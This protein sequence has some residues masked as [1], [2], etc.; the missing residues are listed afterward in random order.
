MS[1]IDDMIREMCPDEVNWLPLER[2]ASN[3]RGASFQK[4]HLSSEGCPCIHY[5]EIYTRYGLHASTTVSFVPPDMVNDQSKACPGSVILSLTSE[6]LLD[7]C[8]PVVW[9]GATEIA[10]SA[11]AA[12]VE[13]DPT[14]MDPVFLAH[15]FASERFQDEKPKIAQGTKIYHTSI[16]R[17]QRTLVPVPP[18]PIQK[19]IVRILDTFTQL[20]AELEAELEARKKQYE[21]YLEECFTFDTS[22]PTKEVRQL[23][24]F[25]NGLNKGKDFFGKGSPIINFTD[26]FRNRFLT[27]DMIRGCVDV[28]PEE[29]Q[30]FSARAGDLF[31]TRTSETQEE[32]G[33]S[34]ALVDDVPDCVFSGFV[35]RARPTTS[36][37]LPKYAAYFFSTHQAR[38]EIVRTSTFTTRALTSGPKLGHIRVPLP[39]LEQQERVVHDLDC[40]NALCND[41]TNGIPA[42]IEARRKQYEYYRDKLL[43]FPRKEA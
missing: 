25:K 22:T 26:V 8:T 28:T 24:E 14:Q 19:E 16:V 30:R 33:M 2:V 43:T 10:V 32:I 27:A 3:R 34:C 7:V 20:V 4:K 39:S 35:L 11:D 13:P 42:E 18:L 41:L 38:R 21:W 36:L 1:K 9:E 17:L 6:N 12:I 5:G 37:I 23:W 40:L 15:Y 31:F 29:K